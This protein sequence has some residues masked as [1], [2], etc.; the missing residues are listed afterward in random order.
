MISALSIYLF[1]FT[2]IQISTL[3]STLANTEHDCNCY[4]EKLEISRNKV[5]ELQSQIAELNLKL[6]QR[7]NTLKST[8]YHSTSYKLTQ[9]VD[10]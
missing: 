3:S 6:A 10:H 9:Q 5:E 2:T 4:K 8:V 1:I 7:E